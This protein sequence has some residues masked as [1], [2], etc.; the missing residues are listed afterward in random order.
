VFL[1]FHCTRYGIFGRSGQ[2]PRIVAKALLYVHLG[3][4]KFSMSQDMFSHVTVGS[5]NLE[6]S[7]A[8]Y[9]A[10]LSPLGLVRRE[11]EPDG[12]PPALCWIKAAQSLPRFYVYMPYDRNPATMGNGNMVAFD[13][14]DQG[15]VDAAYAAGIDAGGT[16][17][18]A[19]GLR[20]HY[21]PDYYGAYLR[22]PDGN[23]LHIVH[24]GAG[25]Q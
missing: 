6:R 14:P 22:D 1:S 23:K 15:A 10:L 2:L 9:D 18:G 17:E 12:G 5:S 20:P 4:K 7:G 25:S 16:C 8:F 19:P 11:M 13:A 3:A 21:G 24:R